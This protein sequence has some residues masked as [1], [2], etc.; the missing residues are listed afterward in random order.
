MAAEL[1][2]DQIRTKIKAT[3]P[4]SVMEFVASAL[5]DSSSGF[6]VTGGQAGRRGDF[7]TSPEVGPLFGAVIARVVDGWWAQLGRPDV[8]TVVECGAGPGTLARAL[9]IADCRCRETGALEWV[10]LEHS[11]AQREQ[12]PRASW[13]R[14]V[15][16][17]DD[18]AVADAILANELLDNLPFAIVRRG[19]NGWH[20]L[21]VAVTR[22]GEFEL[23]TGAA[24]I[25]PAG[26]AGLETGSTLPRH[27]GA[28]RWLETVAT[29]YPNARLLVLDYGASCAEISS[30]GMDWLRAYRQHRRLT[31]WLQN[32]GTVD[33]T[34]DLAVE[35]IEAA[36]P[37]AVT[38]TQTDFLR[39][40]GI[41]DL[42]TE[43]QRIWEASA[44][45]GDLDAIRGRSRLGEAAALCDPDGMG[46]FLVWEW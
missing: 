16:S 4:L 38:Q 19:E 36:R 46:A 9:G 5:Y 6:Y 35:Q 44:S 23:V 13:C 43:G 14:S 41:D 26:G 30:R 24:T 28:V 33:I 17:F 39:Q 1:L 27:D 15:A 32:P 45:R 11:A 2:A 31:D 22:S 40:H 8:F 20:E 42:V 18:V 7:L 29:V 12:H 10:L 3:G 21:A 25:A 34:V 37:G